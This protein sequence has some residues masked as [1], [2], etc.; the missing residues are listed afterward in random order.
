M[1]DQEFLYQGCR[2]LCGVRRTG[3][4]SFAAHAAYRDGLP[5]VAPM[6]LPAD[7]EA[8]GT[9]A[10]ALR[11]AQQNAMRWTQAHRVSVNPRAA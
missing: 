1:D 2:F 7:T 11:H 8:Y 9:A 3:A 5:G 10:E 4:E 6:T